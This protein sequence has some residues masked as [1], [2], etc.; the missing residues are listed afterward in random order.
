MMRRAR[1]RLARRSAVDRAAAEREHAV[2]YVA[3]D[4]MAKVVE[5]VRARG[6][7]VVFTGGEAGAYNP[8]LNRIELSGRLSTE[9]Q[10]H[11]LLHECGHFLIEGIGDSRSKKY[12]NGYARIDEKIEGRDVIHKIDVIAEEFDAWHRGL[13]LA[14]RLQIY[15]DTDAFN[16]TRAKMLMSYIHWATRRGRV[17]DAE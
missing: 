10:L 12:P 7:D 17:V 13:R 3:I 4:A 1:N 16:K 9:R 2:E 8:K 6:Y 5:W 15:I 11:V 14:E